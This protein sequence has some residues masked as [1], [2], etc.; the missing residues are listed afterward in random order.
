MLKGGWF[1]KPV[2]DI[3]LHLKLESLLK[4]DPIYN[5]QDQTPRPILWQTFAV[6]A[7]FSPVFCEAKVRLK[8]LLK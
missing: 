3:N 4:S 7:L 8:Q 6:A 5:W 1:V 2:S